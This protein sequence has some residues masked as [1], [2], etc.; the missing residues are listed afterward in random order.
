MEGTLGEEV[1]D[2]GAFAEWDR[3]GQEEP[4]RLRRR[5]MAGSGQGDMERHGYR[6]ARAGGILCLRFMH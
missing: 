6:E 1:K 2:T 4:G 5:E 3:A